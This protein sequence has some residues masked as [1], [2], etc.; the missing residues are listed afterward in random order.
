MKKRVSL[1]K[2]T[3]KQGMDIEFQA[4]SAP[5]KANKYLSKLDETQDPTNYVLSAEVGQLGNRPDYY[6]KR[7]IVMDVVDSRVLNLS[8]TYFTGK[9]VLDLGCHNGIIT[10]Q[11]AR[12]HNPSYIKG[13]DI[14]YR[15]INKAVT[16]WASEEKLEVARKT[17]LA[18]NPSSDLQKINQV[19]SR[20]K[21]IPK[22]ITENDKILTRLE[23]DTSKMDEEIL[24]EIDPKTRL[25][26]DSVKEYPFNVSFQVANALNLP[27]GASSTPSDKYDT[28]L[29]L[30][31]T[32]WVHLNF[33]DEGLLKLFEN[34]KE[35]LAI[36]GTLILENQSL[37]SYTKKAKQFPRFKKTMANLKLK[38]ENFESEVLKGLGFMKVSSLKSLNSTSFKRDLLVYKLV[39]A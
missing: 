10:L 35:N 20:I 18:D 21:E 1:S 23:K 36:G 24:E 33:G 27:K 25:P 37:K 12:Y 7:G 8:C 30:S 11:I 16:N 22:S 5:S 15:L 29:C 17:K 9:R 39:G 4:G 32:K 19:I 13:I 38:P 6:E 3:P 28:I 14:D 31:L 26:S 2:R 34:I